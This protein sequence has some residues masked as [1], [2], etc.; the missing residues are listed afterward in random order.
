MRDQE[1]G[2][3]DAEGMS[4]GGW[5]PG[6]VRSKT[7]AAGETTADSELNGGGASAWTS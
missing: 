4:A 1:T 2:R 5:E 3:P 6:A 7:P